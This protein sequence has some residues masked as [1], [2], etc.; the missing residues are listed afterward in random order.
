[1]EPLIIVTSSLIGREVFVQ[2][3]S[4]TTKNIYSNINEVLSDEDFEFK[5][6]LEKLDIKI[7]LDIIHSFID[8]YINSNQEVE[9][10][11]TLNITVNH[12][13]TILKKIENEIILINDEIKSHKQKWF[14]RIR[15]NNIKSLIDNLTLHLNLLDERFDL[16][17]KIIKLK[18]HVSYK[19]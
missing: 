11:K 6:V 13:V 15:P 19:I 7:K 14:Y 4:K 8:N 3:I 17:L 12:I 5:K 16:L 10:N 1:M 2:T 9:N 18:H